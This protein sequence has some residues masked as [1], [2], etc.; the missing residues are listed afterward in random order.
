MR[1]FQNRQKARKR[2]YS[3]PVVAALVVLLLLVI[4]GTW[5]AFQ[6]TR[7]SKAALVESQENYELLKKKERRIQEDI[8][9]MK[10]ESGIEEEIRVQFNAAR[11]GEQTIVIVD[12]K[13]EVIEEPEDTSLWGRMKNW[14]KK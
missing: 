7:I 9:H 8:D 3:L 12:E 10:T 14:F 5:G 4:N 13:K 2:M 6:K 11:E 1:E